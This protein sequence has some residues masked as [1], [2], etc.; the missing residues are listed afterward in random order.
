MKNTGVYCSHSNFDLDHELTDEVEIL[1]KQ[2][3]NLPIKGRKLI[4]KALIETLLNEL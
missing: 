1:E 4:I 3:E 2:I